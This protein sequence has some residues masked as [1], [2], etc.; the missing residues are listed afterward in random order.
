[1]SSETYPEGRIEVMRSEQIVIATIIGWLTEP[2]L[3]E[4][5][6]QLEQ[7]I[8]KEDASL[9]LYDGLYMNDPS[10]ALTLLMQTFTERLS[11]RIAKSAIVVPGYRLAFLS[12][13][14]FGK[15]EHKYRVFY[16]DRHEAIAW[17]KATG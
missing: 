6:Q 13:L 14:A 17:L 12:R 8:L 2:L 3:L 5:Q 10:L 4:L 1:M 7:E 9:V 11:T 16:N 15:D